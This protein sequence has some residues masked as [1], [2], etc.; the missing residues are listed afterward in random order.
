MQFRGEAENVWNYT[1]TIERNVCA[2]GSHSIADPIEVS[3]PL[4]QRSLS[5]HVQYVCI[6]NI[7]AFQMGSNGLN[8]ILSLYMLHFVILLHKSC[9]VRRDTFECGDDG[10][11][12]WAALVSAY[13]LEAYTWHESITECV[14]VHYASRAHATISF[15]PDWTRA[16]HAGHWTLALKW[17]NFLPKSIHYFLCFCRPYATRSDE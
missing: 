15:S 14:C 10:A 11:G 2:V 17:N 6:R 7:P 8:N 4:V 12:V 3:R 1:N 16:T 13:R 5:L 9:V